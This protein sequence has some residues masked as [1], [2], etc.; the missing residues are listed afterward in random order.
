[1]KYSE[2]NFAVIRLGKVIFS[3][4][5]PRGGSTPS[6]SHNTSTGPMS[7]PGGIPAVTGWGTPNGGRDRVLPSPSMKRQ[8]WVIII[9]INLF[10]VM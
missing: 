6:P 5:T 4:F 1:M 8:D 7:L 3:L 2:F 9:I 10:S